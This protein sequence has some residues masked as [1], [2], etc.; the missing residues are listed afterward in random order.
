MTRDRI[1]SV[2][3]RGLSNARRIAQVTGESD[4]GYLL[5][6]RKAPQV[7][8]RNMMMP[9]GNGTTRQS[10]IPDSA[11]DECRNISRRHPRAPMTHPVAVRAE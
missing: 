10:T 6:V 8:L 1:E 2:L 7:E 4:G 3:R 11:R 9:L 5:A